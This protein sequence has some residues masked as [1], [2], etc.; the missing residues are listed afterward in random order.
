VAA[1]LAVA[2]CGGA[3]A[4]TGNGRP[5]SGARGAG[6]AGGGAAARG[7]L[8]PV[9]VAAEGTGPA[10]YLGPE[11]D[12]PALGYVSE[13]V[14]LRLEGPPRD[15]RVPVRIEGG[16]KVRAWLTTA[17]LGAV[18]VRGGRVRG[19]PVSLDVGDRVV[20]RE[21]GDGGLVRVEVRPRVGDARLG[22]FHGWYPA[23]RLDRGV[24][25]VG[26]AAEARGGPGPGGAT[27]AGDAGGPPRGAARG[28]MRTLVAGR[29][30]RVLS[31]P[32]G[33]VLATLLPAAAPVPAEVVRERGELAAVRIGSGPKLLG[34]VERAALGPPAQAVAS[35]TAGGPGA[36][37]G[38]SGDGPGT[39]SP[40]IASPATDPAAGT[41]VGARVGATYVAERLQ[42]EAGLPLLRVRAGARVRFDGRVVG[43]LTRPGL[44][45]EMRRHPQGEVDVF[46]AVDDDVALR[47]MVRARDVVRVSD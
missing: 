21:V 6:E 16:L 43:V 3:Q 39:A 22:P 31:R 42:N 30:T 8:P 46:V 38:T 13:G 27:A 18:V 23:A 5:A 20:V 4:P 14:A 33:H 11:P 32:G 17:R 2:A 47:G 44:A 15:G 12:A 24:P 37:G 36:G 29:E 1:S 26:A 9:L 19:A 35:G 10:L 25:G 7:G 28:E 41:D 34:W 45:R 40:A